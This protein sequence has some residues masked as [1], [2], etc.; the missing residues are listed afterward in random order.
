MHGQGLYK[1]PDGKSYNG[2]FKFDKKDG[3]GIYTWADGKRYEGNFVE[4]TQ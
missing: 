2:E 1:W 4:G 3:Y